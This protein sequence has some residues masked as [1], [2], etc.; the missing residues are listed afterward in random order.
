MILGES[1]NFAFQFCDGGLV[2]G[3]ILFQTSDCTLVLS[4]GIGI[5]P[6]QILDALP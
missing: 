5:L 6:D 4:I 2:D 1:D 3:S